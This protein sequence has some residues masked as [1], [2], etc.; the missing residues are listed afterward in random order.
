M[1]ANL[2]V[3]AQDE[4][5]NVMEGMIILLQFALQYAEMAQSLV[6]NHATTELR[7][8]EK[9]VKKIVQEH[10]QVGTAQA[11]TWK[12]PQIAL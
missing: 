10:Q 4:A 12:Q 8:T 6:K 5:G 11:E 7:M 2:N 1:D 9:D 3:L